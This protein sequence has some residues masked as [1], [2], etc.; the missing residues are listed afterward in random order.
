MDSGV[1][2]EVGLADKT[3]TTLIAGE[4]LLAGV[5]DGVLGQIRRPDEALVTFR[6]RVRP[7]DGVVLD[8][9]GEF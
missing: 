6:T 5:N 9:F 1:D 3:S 4:R 2:G 7:L 8:V